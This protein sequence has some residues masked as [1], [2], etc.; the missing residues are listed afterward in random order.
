MKG[1]GVRYY[2]RA[3]A[4]ITINFPEDRTVCQWCLFCRNEDSLRRWKCMLSGE[5]LV[6]PFLTVGNQCPLVFEEKKEG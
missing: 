3:T 1:N 4:A 6:Y 2:T 5:Y